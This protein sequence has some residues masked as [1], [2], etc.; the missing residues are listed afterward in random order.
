MSAVE[1]YLSKVL[2][3]ELVRTKDEERKK[4]NLL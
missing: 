4:K 3:K 2:D 1:N